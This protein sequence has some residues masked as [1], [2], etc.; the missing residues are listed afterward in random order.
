MQHI[1]LATNDIFATATALAA[2]G[3]EPLAHSANYYDDLE[4]RFGLGADLLDRL[5]AANIMYDRDEGGEFFQLYSRTFGEGIFFEILE[6]RGPYK[7]YGAANAPFRIAA[8]RRA[9]RSA[10]VPKR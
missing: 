3:F 4:A 2:K 7:G 9:N 10:G 6:R 8:Q 5:R 1:A